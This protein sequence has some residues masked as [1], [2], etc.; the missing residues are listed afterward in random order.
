MIRRGA[1]YNE[2]DKTAA[3][4]L[5]EL[6]KGGHIAEGEVDERDIRDVAPEE[7]RGF[8]QHH[9]FAGI[10]VWSYAL[11]RAG[12]SDD[13]P[14][15][16]GSCPCQPFSSAG[17]KTGTSDERHLWPDWFW[18]IDQCRP[19]VVFGEQVASRDGLAWFDIVSHD[20]EARA[21]TVGAVNLPACGVGAPHIRQR[22][23]W[24]AYAD[25]AGS[26]VGS[27]DRVRRESEGQRSRG[28]QFERLGS[29]GRLVD[30]DGQRLEILSEQQ[31]RPEHEAAERT[32]PVN[33]F[34][35]NAEWVYC[36]DEK[37]RAVEPIAQ[38]MADGSSESLGRLCFDRFQR[39]KEEIEIAIGHEVDAGETLSD[40]YQTLSTEAIQRWKTGRL[41]GVLESPILLAFLCQFADQGWDFEESLPCSGPK[42]TKEILRCLRGEIQA[43]RS[44]HQRGLARQSAG[45]YPDLMR[46]L[47][48]ILAR[49]AQ[50]AW[51]DTFDRYAQDGFPL[52]VGGKYRVSRLRGY[53]N[54][55]V[56]PAAAAF[57]AAGMQALAGGH[58]SR[59]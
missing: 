46:V 43:A 9:F 49:H 38:Q 8:T 19:D 2:I 45:K 24:M 48:S 51:G 1:Y 18:L 58:A 29:V 30:A 36:A 14:V 37:W 50:E 44:S 27:L 20:L 10:G 57:I 42:V 59:S 12:W 5:R 33:G 7:L 56:A 52:I 53:G 26:Q 41:S 39:I 55:I 31:A 54:G 32:G 3:A 4:W 28:I 11:R 17:K 35:G 23:Y 47:S 21:Y 6:I 15:W 22:T 16:T 34:W 25:G 13:R 40:L